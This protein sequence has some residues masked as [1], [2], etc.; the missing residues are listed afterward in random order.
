MI[1]TLKSIDTQHNKPN[2]TKQLMPSTLISYIFLHIHAV[3]NTK[4][5]T[6]MR[7]TITI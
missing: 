2:L 6:Y 7:S 3:S 5:Q 1:Y 4:Q